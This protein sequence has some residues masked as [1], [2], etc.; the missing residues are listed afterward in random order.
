MTQH[1]IPTETI[2]ET[3][4]L[5]LR[6]LNAEDARFYL[7]L[8]NDPSFIDNIRDKGIRTIAEAEIAIQTGHRD[9]QL[10]MGFS[11]YL[12]ERKVDQRAIGLCGLVKRDDL[13]GIDIGYAYLPEFGRQG[14][15]YEAN[16]GLLHYAKNTLHL[17]ELLAIVS[18]HNLASCQLLEK[19]EFQ[20]QKNIEL[21]VGD[22]V[23]LFQ[24]K[25]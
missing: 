20:F 22:V 24:R 8:V 10:R 9:V 1:E 25:L 12:V 18:P 19:L 21:K 13:P 3:Q 16:Q 5:R 4:R 2:F 14:F 15:A 11:L 7:R 23:K 17:Q 6:M